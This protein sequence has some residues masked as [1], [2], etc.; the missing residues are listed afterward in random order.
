MFVCYVLGNTVFTD[1]FKWTK[2]V[3]L[4]VELCYSTVSRPLQCYEDTTTFVCKFTLQES[5]A[6]N[7]QTA[8]AIILCA[9]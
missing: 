1:I 8:T 6:M 2:C 7:K 4:K 5:N 3:V 9:L